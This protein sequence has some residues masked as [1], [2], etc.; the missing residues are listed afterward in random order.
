MTM[1]TLAQEAGSGGF[2]IKELASQVPLVLLAVLAIFAYHK[3]ILVAGPTHR[4]EQKRNELLADENARLRASLEEKVLPA[5][6]RSTD[7][8]EK[9]IGIL[10]ASVA[11]LKNSTEANSRLGDVEAT[12]RLLVEQASASDERVIAALKRWE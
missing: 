3:E 5:L 7:L 10:E 11:A 8:A 2:D 1:W 12:V 9:T 4:Q 6:I